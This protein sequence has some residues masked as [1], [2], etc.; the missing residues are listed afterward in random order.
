MY[1]PNMIICT[2][3]GM[4]VLYKALRKIAGMLS[5][6]TEDSCKKVS[7]RSQVNKK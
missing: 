4:G 2:W 6:L 1:N 7:L 5:Q 3:I